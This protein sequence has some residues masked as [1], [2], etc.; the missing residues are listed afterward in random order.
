MCD[1]TSNL[2]ND[3]IENISPTTFMPNPIKAKLILKDILKLDHSNF[4]TMDS[5]SKCLRL[6]SKK[7]KYQSSKRELGMIYRL[8][9][10]KDPINYPYIDDL[11]NILI[12]KSVRSE[13]GIV[14]VSVSLPPDRFSCKYNCYFCPNEPGMPRSYLSNEDVFKRASEVGFDTVLQVYNRFD[15]LEKW[16]YN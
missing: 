12:N 7:Y 1:F 14:N 9:N 16:T 13:S 5:L 3:D 6:I 2:E 11:W 4:I 10:K 8:L 15:V